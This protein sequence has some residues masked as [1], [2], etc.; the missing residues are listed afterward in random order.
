MGMPEGVALGGFPM[1]CAVNM[2]CL[3]ASTPGTF[4][5]QQGHCR[6]TKRVP[7]ADGVDEGA[8]CSPLEYPVKSCWSPPDRSRTSSSSSLWVESN[9]GL[10]RE[11]T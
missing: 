11:E 10:G 3:K 8:G 4:S 7:V 1:P 5:G 6:A 9:A 2:W